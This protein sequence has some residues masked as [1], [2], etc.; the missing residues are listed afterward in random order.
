MASDVI[1]TLDKAGKTFAGPAGPVRAL[2]DVS[3]ELRRGELAAV[4]GPSGSGKSTL[5]LLAGGLMK[6]TEGSVGLNG[7]SWSAR[8]EEPDAA[9]RARQAGFVFQQFHLIP[10]LTVFENIMTAALAAGVAGAEIRALELAAAF[11][12]ESRLR[13]VPAALSAGEQQRTALARALLNRPPLILADEPTGNLDRENGR[14]VIG[15]L[16]DYVTQGG[17]VV[18]VTHDS[19]AASG[20]QR[21]FFLKAGILQER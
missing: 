15:A 16:R 1:L 2:A 6:P 11:G 4:E 19:E 18:L 13:H 7:R 3:L 9:W 17:A 12:L 8:S 14:L 10:Y 20:A 5:L 21:R